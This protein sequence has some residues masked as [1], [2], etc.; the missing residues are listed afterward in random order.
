MTGS[1][2]LGSRL[3][4]HLCL[5]ILI[6]PLVAPA[7]PGGTAPATVVVVIRLVESDFIARS[8]MRMRKRGIPMIGYDFKAAFAEE[9]MTRLAADKRAQYRLATAADGIPGLAPAIGRSLLPAKVYKQSVPPGLDAARTL[10]IDIGSVGSYSALGTTFY[11][12]NATMVMLDRT[13]K[14]VWSQIDYDVGPSPMSRGGCAVKVS[15]SIEQHQDDGQKQMKE[16]I[17][18][19]IEKYCA[20][21][22]KRLLAKQF[23]D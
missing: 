7:A 4:A 8:G 1:T 3:I 19:I 15:G 18:K 9:L 14:V 5:G 17:N 10:R 2:H 12:I 21:K 13:G 6:S 11:M 22:A 20:S 23:K 16:N